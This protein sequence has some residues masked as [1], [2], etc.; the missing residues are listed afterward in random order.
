MGLPGP[1]GTPG[2]AGQKGS[3]FNPS[4]QQKSFFSYKRVI[5]Q[6]PQLDTDIHFDRSVDAASSRKHH[7]W[8]HAT[9]HVVL[10]QL[11]GSPLSDASCV[12]VLSDILDLGER[13]RGEAMTEGKFTCAIAGI[14][15]FSYH[16]SA[17]SRVSPTHEKRH[18]NTR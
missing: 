1:P 7:H 4:N 8:R 9:K 17:K 16:L 12:C 14:Y 2:L 6:A 13:F 11:V 18:L 5:S 15:F 10:R 3:P